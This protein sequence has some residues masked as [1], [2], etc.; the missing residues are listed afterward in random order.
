[1]S[2]AQL[3]VVFYA[4]IQSSFDYSCPLF[5]NAGVTLDSRLIS[6]CKRAFH[7]IHGRDVRICNECNL[8][9]VTNR[10]RFFSLKLFNSALSSPHHLLHDLLPPF[11]HRSRRLIL[12][13]VRTSRR[14]ESFVMACSLLFNNLTSM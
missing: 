3:I 4:L 10:R 14:L 7:I 11:S 6:L 2:H 1:M 9:D 12:P 5:M 8:M 13:P